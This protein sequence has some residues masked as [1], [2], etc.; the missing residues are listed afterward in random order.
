MIPPIAA[1]VM[2]YATVPFLR[3]RIE[4][5]LGFVWEPLKESGKLLQ[6]SIPAAIGLIAFSIVWFVLYWMH[7]H[8]LYI[9]I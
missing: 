9:R 3:G 8:R 4:S 7:K 5:W 1:Y 2:S 6:E